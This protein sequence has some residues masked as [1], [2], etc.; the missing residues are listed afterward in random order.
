LYFLYQ[1]GEFYAFPVI[2]VDT[3][4]FKK[5]TLIKRAGVRTS[6][7]PPGSALAP[8]AKIDRCFFYISTF[9]QQKLVSLLWTKGHFWTFPL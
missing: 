7:T 9:L 3:V 6:R 5:G 4:L 2:F 8:S 1:N